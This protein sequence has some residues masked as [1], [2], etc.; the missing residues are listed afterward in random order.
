MLKILIINFRLSAYTMV[1]LIKFTNHV[2]PKSYLS[3]LVYTCSHH[4]F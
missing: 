2:Y 1:Y 3:T 4:K